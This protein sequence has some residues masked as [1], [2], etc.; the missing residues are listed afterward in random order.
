MSSTRVYAS[1]IVRNS[2]DKI[3]ILQRVEDARFAPG[4]WEFVNGTIEPHETAEET[5][6]RELR[7]ETGLHIG[8]DRL[9]PAPVHELIDS[10]G[11]WIVIPFYAK[12]SGEV[13]ISKEH[14]N[15]KWETREEVLK[16]PFVG[17]DYR[18]LLKL[19]NKL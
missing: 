9:V 5:A 8:Q 14:Q 11:R 17:D 7:E 2:D 10:D 18:E 12:I 13:R 19:E 16:T 6:V 1:V 15:Y 4:Q 3:L